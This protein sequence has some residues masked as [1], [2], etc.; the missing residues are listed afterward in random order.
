MQQL[1][2][3]LKF[4]VC[5]SKDEV[6]NARKNLEGKWDG[7][8]SIPKIRSQHYFEMADEKSLFIARTEQ[9]EKA[10]C[11]IIFK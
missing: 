4:Y 8:V 3:I 7:I 2:K 6:D 10:K 9:S 11:H 5:I 1:Y